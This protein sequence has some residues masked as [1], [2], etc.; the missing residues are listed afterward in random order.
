MPPR[1]VAGKREQGSLMGRLSENPSDD[2]A[3]DVNARCDLYLSFGAPIVAAPAS[4]DNSRHSRAAAPRHARRRAHDPNGGAAPAAPARASNFATMTRAKRILY[5]EGNVDGT[6]GG[7]FFSLFFLTSGLDRSR[8]EPVVYFCADN[9]LIPRFRAAGIDTRVRPPAAPFTSRTLPRVMTKLIN[10]VRGFVLEPLRLAWLLKRERIDMVHLNNAIVRN[11]SWMIAARLCALPC[12]T[13]ERG[14]ND[15]YAERSQVLGREL[16]AVICISGAV[17]SNFQARN[18]RGLRLVTVPNGLD[19][20]QM[21]VTQEPTHIR[22][23]LAIPAHMRV[24]GIVGNIKQWKGQEIVIRAMQQ[25][26]ETMPD[27][28]CLLIGD[29]SPDDIEYRRHVERLIRDLGLERHIIVTGY[30][31]NVSDYVNALEVLIHASVA[32]EPFGRVLLEGMALRK[33]LVASNGGAVPEIVQHGVTGLLFTPGDAEDLARA[34]LVLLGNRELVCAMGEAG[35]TRLVEHFGI[36]SN[37]RQTQALYEEIFAG[38]LPPRDSEQPSAQALSP[39][40]PV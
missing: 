37:V 25:V 23:E 36:D 11:H 24:I 30:R 15:S 39:A 10:F 40:N 33:P 20:R 35:F 28:V 29:S 32:P 3:W 19:H 6:V 13:H 1:P 8:F 17:R 7:S 31:S 26:R 21:R 14:I 4:L 34:L 22:A 5:V 9:P 18:V 2:A 12:V 16:A 38:R 27:V